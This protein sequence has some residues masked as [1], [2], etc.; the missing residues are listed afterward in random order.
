MEEATLP[1]RPPSTTTT[2]DRYG[3]DVSPTHRAIADLLYAIVPQVRHAAASE[4][5]AF[6]FVPVPETPAAWERLI[7]RRPACVEWSEAGLP[8]SSPRTNSN[9]RWKRS[10]RSAAAS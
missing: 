3:I 9:G 5:W 4:S 1:G 10:A 8:R 6:L 2:A 7:K